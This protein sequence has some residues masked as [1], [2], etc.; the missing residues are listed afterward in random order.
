MK[1]FIKSELKKRERA[2]HVTRCARINWKVKKPI[3]EGIFREVFS[4]MKADGKDFYID[5]DLDDPWSGKKYIGYDCIQVSHPLR[6]TGDMI[7][8]KNEKST[9]Y[10]R[11]KE[12]GSALSITC[13]SV[14]SYDVFL[15]P[16]KNDNMMKEKDNIILYSTYDPRDFTRKRILG[17]IRAYLIFQRVDSIME[18]ASLIDEL[19]IAWLYFTD[20]R[21]REKRRSL[22]FRVINHWGAVALSAALA[23]FIA[24]NTQ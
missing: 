18:K 24:K 16:A 4:F 20:I 7:I 22:Y 8:T 11:K 2:K 5:N 13:S 19:Q 6:L 1:G 9:N 12:V 14:G 23:W 10:D 15:I 17:F 3:I 21:N